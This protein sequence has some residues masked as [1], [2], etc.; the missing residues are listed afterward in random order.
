MKDIQENAIQAFRGGLN[1]A[2]AVYSAFSEK[3]GY[4]KDTA[5]RASTGFGG[6]MGRMQETCG[7]VTGA[8]MVIGMYSSNLYADM[9]TRKEKS[10]EMIREFNARFIEKHQSAKCKDLIICDLNT[11]EGKEYARENR[12]HETIC[13]ACMLTSIQLLNEL[14]L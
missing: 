12:V 11:E 6:G 1:C 3:V 13:E 10:Y 7:V 8:F 4:D 5:I 9:I 14:M 2:Q